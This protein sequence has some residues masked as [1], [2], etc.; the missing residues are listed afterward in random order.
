MDQIT[1]DVDA[2]GNIHV[3]NNTKQTISVFVRRDGSLMILG[4]FTFIPQLAGDCDFLVEAIV[5]C[6][7]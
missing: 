3:F 7:D 4:E 6:A 5:R 1:I 2:S